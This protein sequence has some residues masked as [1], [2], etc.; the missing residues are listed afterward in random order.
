MD[1]YESIFWYK[2]S[3]NEEFSLDEA[4]NLL[5]EWL[6]QYEINRKN[7]GGKLKAAYYLA[8]CYSAM[9]INSNSY[10]EDYI[11]NAKNILN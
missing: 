3:G 2:M 7:G 8:V 5:I 10:N 6:H 4:V 1:S 9:A 11:R